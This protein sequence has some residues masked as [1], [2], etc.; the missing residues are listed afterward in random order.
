MGK[1]EK[2]INGLILTGAAVASV[3]TTFVVWEGYERTSDSIANSIY[4]VKKIK[5]LFRRD[6]YYKRNKITGKVTKIK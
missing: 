6:E 5:H 4:D 3:I 1:N 2:F